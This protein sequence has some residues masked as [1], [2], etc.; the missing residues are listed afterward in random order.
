LS[1]PALVGLD[2]SPIDFAEN[3]TF[4]A[5]SLRWYTGSGSGTLSLHPMHHIVTGGLSNI[6]DLRLSVSGGLTWGRDDVVA[7][8]YS[9]DGL[10]TRSGSGNHYWDL[11][12]ASD[13]GSVLN[14]SSLQSIYAGFNDGDGNDYNIHRII[15]SS[16]G[17]IDF[18]QV[19]TVTGPYYGDDRLEFIV[20]ELSTIDL[21][22]LEEITSTS[23]GPVQFYINRDWTL[24]VLETAYRGQ[25]TLAEGKTLSLPALV[26]LDDSPIDFAENSTFAAPSLTWYTGSGSDTLSLNPM[27]H[28]G[29]GPQ[30]VLVICSRAERSIVESSSTMNSKRSSP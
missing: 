24:D 21:S 3:S 15:A 20:D 14:L 28:I 11:F 30:L 22:A 16:G 8:S 10:W 2:D 5:P 12:K 6:T 26:G 27:R 23:W 25:F 7:A 9:S 19:R 17:H 18:S 29:T 1:L 13:E 4:A